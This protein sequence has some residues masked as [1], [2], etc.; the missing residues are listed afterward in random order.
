[1]S[2][3]DDIEELLFVSKE[4]AYR[5][6]KKRI[7]SACVDKDLSFVSC[8]E[9]EGVLRDPHVVEGRNLCTPCSGY[10][11]ICSNSQLTDA[12]NQLRCKCP[13]QTRGCDWSG[14]LSDLIAHM[15]ECG[16][17][18]FRCPLGCEL[19]LNRNDV[20][21]HTQLSCP[22]SPV[23]CSFSSVGCKATDLCR[24]N[25]SDH[26]ESSVTTHQAM[27]LSALLG[28]RETNLHHREFIVRQDKTIKQH[29]EMVKQN[30]EY[31]L[32]HGRTVNE[33]KQT[34]NENTQTIEHH[35]KSI[36]DQRETILSDRDSIVRHGQTIQQLNHKI[37]SQN[38]QIQQLNHKSESQNEHIQQLNHKI[39]SQDKHIQKLNHKIES[40]NEQI[41]Q[42]NHRIEILFQMVD[43]PLGF[44]R[45]TTQDRIFEK[46]D[47]KIDN[48]TG[49]NLDPTVFVGPISK[50]RGFTFRGR[51]EFQPGT[52]MLKISVVR[53][54]YPFY[55]DPNLYIIYWRLKFF[56]TTKKYLVFQCYSV[57]GIPFLVG[58]KDSLLLAEVNRDLVSKIIMHGGTLSMKINLWFM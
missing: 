24:G 50:I 26:M 36:V 13:L 57:D 19:I 12:I 9:C 47:W 29:D 25:L 27:L 8:Q 31:L 58:T 7:V 6:Y 45:E 16:Y 55:P 54:P 33:N 18:T 43:N 51:M 37:E 46:M 53:V 3:V 48:Y 1:M 10:N 41:Q 5:G 28:M 39:E 35:G 23:E 11:A 4:G 30:Q 38:E 56:H 21:G 52:N 32:L 40:Q 17:I 34:I 22:L 49:T 42:L 2:E 14:E 15:E 20:T 44:I